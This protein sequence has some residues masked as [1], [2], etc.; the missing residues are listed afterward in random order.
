MPHQMRLWPERT[1]RGYLFDHRNA[2]LR[3]WLVQ[4]HVLG[5]FGMENENVQGMYFDDW[6]AESGDAW[7]LGPLDR[8][9]ETETISTCPT[10]GRSQ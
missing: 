3:K 7:Y 9:H 8:R 5:A 10:Q 6:W 2:S 1:M 4:E